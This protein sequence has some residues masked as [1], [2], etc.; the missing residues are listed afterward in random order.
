[1][2]KNYRKTEKNKINNLP[3]LAHD[4]ENC[5]ESSSHINNMGL[6]N[7]YSACKLP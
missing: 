5:A 7:A 4:L 3:K 6:F 1:M 2:L